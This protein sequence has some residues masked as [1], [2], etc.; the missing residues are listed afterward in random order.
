M[1]SAQLAILR[2]ESINVPKLK[3]LTKSKVALLVTL[4]LGEFRHVSKSRI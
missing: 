4:M 1:S 2:P 3:K